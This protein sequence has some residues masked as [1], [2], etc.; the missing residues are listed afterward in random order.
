MHPKMQLKINPIITYKKSG[1]ILPLNY[2]TPL[3]RLRRRGRTFIFLS[4]S[5]PYYKNHIPTILQVGLTLLLLCHSHLLMCDLPSA[6]SIPHNIV[7]ISNIQHPVQS[8]F[9]LSPPQQHQ[10]IWCGKY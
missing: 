5:W 4:L 10:V 6:T 1:V 9:Y 8:G 3:V 7:N 2:A